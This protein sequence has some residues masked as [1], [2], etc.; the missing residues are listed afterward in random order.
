MTELTLLIYVGCTDFNY[1][2]L[3]SRSSSN[4]LIRLL[5]IYVKKKRN[6]PIIFG[7]FQ[8]IFSDSLLHH[9]SVIINCLRDVTHASLRRNWLILINAPWDSSPPSQYYLFTHCCN[10]L[11]LISDLYNFDTPFQNH[12]EHFAICRGF[13]KKQTYCIIVF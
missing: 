8:W 13:D 9:S 2:F 1:A 7:H 4:T 3:T 6:S 5:W 10:F 11:A 12:H